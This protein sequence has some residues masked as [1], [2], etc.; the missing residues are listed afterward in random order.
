MK[1]IADAI[2]RLKPG[3]EFSYK[4]EDY[5]TI[6]WDVLEGDAPTQKEINDTIKLLEKEEI[7]QEASDAKKKAEILDRLGITAD[8]A[9]LLL[10]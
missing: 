7:A 8:E 10:S 1:R 6:V 3:A 2:H 9:K 4:D 5:S